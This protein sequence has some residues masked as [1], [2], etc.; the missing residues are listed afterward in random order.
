MTKS[1][2]AKDKSLR[3]LMAGVQ[4]KIDFY[5]RDYKWETK[6]VE[7]LVSDLT[8]RFLD[9]FDPAHVRADVAS[10]PT[11]F[12]GSVVMSKRPEGVFIVDGQQR[13][14]TI[15]LLLIYLRNLQL[16]GGMPEDPNVQQ[17]IQ[18]TQFGSKSFNLSIPERSAAIEALY[19][20]STLPDDP[21]DA[22]SATVLDRYSDIEAVFPDACKGPALAFFMDW[23]VERVQ[24]V[25]ISAYS[26]EDAYSVFETMNDRGLSLSPA[27]MLK[28]YLLSNIRGAKDRLEAENSWNSSVRALQLLGKDSTDEFFRAWLRGRYATSYGT[29]R[30]DFE[31]LG[32][33]FHR[34]LRD[35][36][37]D[38]GLCHSD[39]FFRFVDTELPF[40]ADLYRRL[41]NDQIS[42]T[43]GAETI[44][45]TG[46]ARLDD[47]M[48][49]MAAS[50]PKH[51][52][53]ESR[54]RLKVVAR[55]LDIFIHRRVWA[56]RI[57]TRPALKG[58][59]M[60]LARDLRNLELPELTARLYAE[61]TKPGSDNFSESPPALSSATRR[62][63]HRLLARLTS[64]V[65]VEAGSG[66][67]PY[68][69]LVVH[70]GRSRF[71]IEH[72]WPD[73]YQQYA[74]LFADEAEF[75][76]YRNRLG[77][78]V[79][80][81]HSYNISYNDMPTS[82]KLP[83]YG[84]TDHH[85]LVA[86][87][88]SSSYDRNPLFR[89]LLENTD[90]PFQPF[91]LGGFTKEAS[92]SRLELYRQLARKIWSPQLLLADSELDQDE[93]RDIALQLHPQ[94]EDE[95]SGTRRVRNSSNVS[96]RDLI[97]SGQLAAGDILIGRR[98][99]VEASATAI[100]LED[101]S[102]ELENGERFAAPSAAAM[103]LGLDVVINGWDF[104]LHERTRR[105]LRDLRDLLE[106]G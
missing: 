69:D 3:Q 67:D 46:E 57:L 77:S 66:S 59:F 60:S 23:L 54:V 44:Y 17:L 58:S 12:M 78:L 76:E 48:L 50:T 29:S 36:S 49:Y 52:P 68:S 38:V 43:P 87:L 55:Y 33:E 103:A 24:L 26:D 7:E 95:A 5:Q 84:R 73:Q 9:F 42:H 75:R 98:D 61:L 34:W 91:D 83:L 22:S 100:V 30:D 96:V 15:S 82:E 20:Q 62:K 99:G 6:Q 81:P 32:P 18:S 80:I 4:Y 10:Y 93:I 102:I 56:S 106:H 19:N 74:E 8:N 28:G 40:Y 27:D 21:D 86:S 11:Y 31:R 37:E 16:D 85:L 45:Y 14:T 64:Y 1:I 65:E 2:D 71:D 92:N 104:W 41:R 72:I 105:R 63:I 39:D 94:L 13:L 79:L 70:S 90:L 88:A 97:V 25:E 101:G 35:H 53:D 89:R 47:L 51:L